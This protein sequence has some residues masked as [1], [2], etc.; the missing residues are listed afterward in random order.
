MGKLNQVIAIEKGVKSRVQSEVTELYK[1][2]QKPELFSGF[3]KSYTKKDDEGEDFPPEKKKVQFRVDD[4]L[5]KAQR[6]MTELMEVTARKDW[7]NCV[8]RA[9]VL[10]DQEVVIPGA[11]ITYLLFLE[12]QLTDLRTMIG[13]LPLLDEADTWTKDDNA[14]LMRTDAIQT[15]RTKKV[16]KPIVLYNATPEHPAQTQLI[17]EDNVV[18]YWSAIKHSGAM[19]KPDKEALLTRVE[20]LL[21]GV[22]VAREKANMQEEE[23]APSVG[24][25]IFGYLLAK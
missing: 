13:A 19:S 4:L 6:S 3:V 24:D 5:R 9:D 14:A 12:K 7:T 1:V 16:Q 21:K 2:A 22:K 8:A 18:G 15:H 25:A 20:T 10:V 23:I 11:P 17:T